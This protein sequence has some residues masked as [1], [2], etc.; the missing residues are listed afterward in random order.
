[1]TQWDIVNMGPHLGMTDQNITLLHPELYPQDWYNATFLGT[2]WEAVK[3]SR[4][5][6]AVFISP[7]SI[8]SSYISSMI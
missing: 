4:P 5:G 1:M 2:D 7:T 6:I 3:N 8:C